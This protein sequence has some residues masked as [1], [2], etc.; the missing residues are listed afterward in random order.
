MKKYQIT[1][2]LESCG[3][4]NPVFNSDGSVSCYDTIDNE[5]ATFTMRE[6][7]MGCYSMLISHT[8]YL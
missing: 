2:L 4:D 3:Y 8:T 7:N 6:I 5:P 1:E